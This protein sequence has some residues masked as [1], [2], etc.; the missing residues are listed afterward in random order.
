MTAVALCSRIWSG[1]CG[2]G[3]P[4][5]A[6]GRAVDEA[7]DDCR[8]EYDEFV[9][10]GKRFLAGG[11]IAGRG[12][13]TGI[14]L[15]Q[16]IFQVFTHRRGLVVQEEDFDNRDRSPRSR[17]AVGVGDVAGEPCVGTY[18]VIDAVGDR[19]TSA[20]LVELTSIRRSSGTIGVQ[21]RQRHA[22]RLPGPRGLCD[23]YAD[24]ASSD[25]WE[26]SV[27]L[28]VDHEIAVGRGRRVR[29]AASISGARASG[30]EDDSES[31]Y[32]LKFRE[33]KLVRFTT[34]P[35]T[36]TGISQP[37]GCRSRR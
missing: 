4:I 1:G 12:R 28:D 8:L 35:R 32:M 18:R 37:W 22:R 30:V 2:A 15:D 9:D 20:A 23:E 25:A 33:A 6:S 7:Y 34:V 5:A 17:G 11:R 16:P 19:G 31:G 24:E 3:R 21:M 27:R 26:S 29:A 14:A 10:C 36:R 13:H